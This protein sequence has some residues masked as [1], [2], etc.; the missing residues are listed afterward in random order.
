MQGPAC[1]GLSRAVL[2]VNHLSNVVFPKIE[3]ASDFDEILININKV[4]LEIILLVETPR[5]FLELQNVLLENSIIIKG[6]ALGSHDFMREIG[7]DH[8]LKNL[9]YPRI[10]LLYLARMI[11]VEAI[12]IASMELKD[13]NKVISEIL[14]GFEKGYDAK[15]YIHPWQISVKNKIKLYT[16]DEFIWAKK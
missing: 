11:K 7:G 4:G 1:R 14:D 16:E 15:F 9:E 12:D 6:I 13:E 5:F 3:K 2:L 8:S 10:H